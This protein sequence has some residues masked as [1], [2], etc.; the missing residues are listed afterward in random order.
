MFNNFAE[1]REKQQHK[2][3]RKQKKTKTRKKLM[4]IPKPNQLVF[5]PQNLRG[6]ENFL[7]WIQLLQNFKD[8]K[9]LWLHFVAC[10]HSC[11]F[12]EIILLAL[13][14]VE[15]CCAESPITLPNAHKQSRFVL[16]V[17]NIHTENIFLDAIKVF[18][19]SRF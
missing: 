17:S 5:L 15:F 9:N 8:K 7:W 4:M 13:Y 12:S 11:F 16:S 14:V 18:H 6:Q 1:N 2:K 10:C 19:V 3:Q